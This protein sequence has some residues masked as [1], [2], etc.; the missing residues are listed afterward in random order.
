MRVNVHNVNPV[1]FNL[2]YCGRPKTLEANLVTICLACFKKAE[3]VFA[4]KSD[5]DMVWMFIIIFPKFHNNKR[6][7]WTQE[8]NLRKQF[9]WDRLIPFWESAKSFTKININPL[10][11]FKK[12]GI[13][14][15]SKNK[16]NNEFSC[17]SLSG[18]QLKESKSPFFVCVFRLKI[19]ILF[20]RM[21]FFEQ[22][23]KTM[24]LLFHLYFFPL[25]IL[26]VH[27]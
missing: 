5:V 17:R 25:I 22:F 26:K 1:N 18:L 9:K 6:K 15:K 4:L 20:R 13:L 10:K 19:I 21:H 8:N 23:V 27:Y 16:S 7:V 12:T 11:L 3:Y 2:K 24:F 14:S